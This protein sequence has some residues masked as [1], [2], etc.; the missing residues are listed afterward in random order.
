MKHIIKNLPRY[1][2]ILIP[3]LIGS[4]GGFYF[5]NN[6]HPKPTPIQSKPKIFKTK[7]SAITVTNE[8]ITTNSIDELAAIISIYKGGSA[9]FIDI[10]DTIITPKSNLFR[11]GSPYA[12]I[13]DELKKNPNVANFD[14]ILGNWRLQRKTML[15][16]DRWPE[17]IAQLKKEVPVFALTQLNPGK[18][19]PIA[20]MEQW[21]HQE[22]SSLN[23]AFTPIFNNNSEQVILFSQEK[24]YPAIF[25]QGFFITGSYKKSQII[26]EYIKHHPA[27]MIIFIDDRKEH[28]DEVT[29]ACK[30][31]GIPI[32]GILYRGIEKIQGS[33]DPEV[34]KFQQQYL[35]EHAEWLEDEVAAARVKSFKR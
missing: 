6:I 3:F 28:I 25:Y 35:L 23:V 15:V 12:T 30:L 7:L 18:I 26:A 33:A 11:H 4:L 22:L 9:I 14:N 16:S 24:T 2:K 19:G 5:V 32:V 17:L 20:S 29:D 1:S 31:A 21:R 10:D 13:I 27:E 8:I 34:A